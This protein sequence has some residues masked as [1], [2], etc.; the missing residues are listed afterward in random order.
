MIKLARN[1]LINNV[2]IVAYAD[3]MVEY[4]G[5]RVKFIIIQAAHPMTFLMKTHLCFPS[6]IISCPDAF[7]RAEKIALN[8][9]I[10][11]IGTEA[12]YC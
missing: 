7:E 10:R 11:S 9:R 8:V 5:I 3:P 6:M 1:P 12:R 4:F 2:M